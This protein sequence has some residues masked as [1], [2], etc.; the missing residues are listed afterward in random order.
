ME[1]MSGANRRILKRCLL[2]LSFLLGFQAASFA[3]GS[4]EADFKKTDGRDNWEYTYDIS[5]M[6]PGKYNLIVEGKDKAGNVSTA[7]PYNVYIDPKSDLPVAGISNPTPGLRVGGDLHIVGT[8]VDDDGVDRVEVKLDDGEFVKADGREY[9]SYS[10][11]AA[12]MADGRHTVSA[13]GVDINGLVGEPV[14]VSFNLD[15]H[16]PVIAIV[17]H[18]SGT[19]VSGTVTLSGTA[20]DAN[21]IKS[22]ACSQDN[23]KT[24][25]EL[26]L[27]RGKDDTSAQFELTVDT[28][29]LADGPYAYWFGSLD[30]TGSTGY[31]AFLLFVDNTGPS[32]EILKPKSDE[33]VSGRVAVIGKITE[34]IGIKSFSYDGGEANRGAIE[35]APGNPY[36]IHEFDFSK[37]RASSA[38][39]LFTVVD[40]VGNTTTKDLTVQIL[41]DE[42]DLPVV[43]LRS[44][45]A[46]GVYPA[47]VLLSGSVRD[48]DGVK[49]VQYSIDGGKPV[50]LDSR[51]AFSAMLTELPAGKHKL[52]IH[53][54]DTNDRPGKDVTVEFTSRGKPPAVTVESVSSGKESVPFRPGFEIARDKGAVL[55]GRISTLGQLKSLE[56]SLNGAPA[57]KLSTKGADKAGE[58]SF[59][60]RIPPTVS[61][62]MVTLSVRATDQSDQVGEFKSIIHVTNYSKRNI[63][64]GIYFLQ[65]R[66][67][68]DGTILLTPEMPLVGIFTGEEIRSVSIEPPSDVLSIALDGEKIT[69]SPRGTGAAGPLH[70]KVV[71]AKGRVFTS[72]ELGFQADTSGGAASAAID[73]SRIV[74]GKDSFEYSPG[75]RL[76]ID[77][78]TLLTGTAAIAAQVKSAEYALQG[79]PARGF[80]LKKLDT[81]GQY[82][83]EIPLPPELPYGKIDLRMAV[84]DASG[85]K[86]VL[87]T[88]FFRVEKESGTDNDGEGIYLADSRIDSTGALLLAPGESIGGYFNG[89]P[90]KEIRLDPDTPLLSAAADG[91][92][93]RLSAVK[94]GMPASVR[95]RLTTVDGDFFQSDPYTVRSDAG[96]PAVTVDS[97]RTGDWVGAR[98]RLKGSAS[99]PNGI[100]KL[101]YALNSSDAFTA[102]PPAGG[103][104][105]SGFDI[106]LDLA[107]VPDG[108]VGLTVRAADG[109]G[110][111]SVVSLRFMK[112]SEG[113]AISLVTPP[114]EDPVNGLITVTGTATDAGAVDQVEFSDDG[115]TYA[116]VTGTGVFSMPLDLSKYTKLPEAFYFRARDKSGNISVFTAALNVQ[117]ETDIPTVQIQIP[118]DGEVL[119]SDFTISGMVFDDDGVGSISYRIDQGP[120]QKLPGSNSFDIPLRLEDMSDNEHAIEVMAEDLNGVPS[121]SATSTFKISKAEPTSR[122]TS[123]ALSTTTRGVITLAGESMDKNGI[124]EISISFDNGQTFNLAEGKEKWAYRL[125]TQILK[126]GTYSIIIKAVDAYGTEGLFS[127]LL[128]IDNQPPQIILD[129]PKDGAPVTE[130]LAV[131][132]RAIDNIDLTSLKATLAPLGLKGSSPASWDLPRKGHFSSALDLKAVAAGWYNLTLEATDKAEN[133]A[134][135]SR[136]V[137]V[138]EKKAVNTV[139]ILFPVNGESISGSFT[140]AG[141]VQSSEKVTEVG[142]SVDGQAAGTIPMNDNGYFTMAVTPESLQDG[143][144]S[145]EAQARLAGDLVIR[146]EPRSIVYRKLGPWIRITSNA[147]GDFVTSRPF[148]TGEAGFT[149]EPADPA[150]K[151]AVARAQRERDAHRIERIEVSLDNGKSFTAV[152][153]REKWQYRLE[154]QNYPDGEVRFIARAVFTDGST[155]FD[156]TLLTI[157]DTPPQVVLLSPREEGRFNGEISLLGTA[158][159]EN[160]IS[161]VRAAVRQGDK[162]NYEVPGF[163]QGLYFE[164]HALGA[165]EWDFGIGLTFFDDNVKLQAQV[166]TAPEGRFSGLVIGTKL[167]ANI[168]RLPFSYFLG[169]DWDLLSL[170]LAI[171]ANFSYVTNSG[172]AIAFTDKGLII[173]GVVGQLEFPIVKLKSWPLFRTYS[174]Y[175]E[176]QLW[177]ISSDISAGFVSRMA[178]GARIGLF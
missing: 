52:A 148:I 142:F 111:Q 93:I 98:L 22:L 146:S 9:W 113:P 58:A 5:T 40:L 36:W 129:T 128:N 87:S 26:P 25:R 132:G 56:C 127:T 27:R 12:S 90:V 78:S 141:R 107:D 91:N 159:D 102:I 88:S 172:S 151:E 149:S 23:K 64:P 99:D 166:G 32:I 44:P 143:T 147:P 134:K 110:R 34:R 42:A 7:G 69:V 123:P 21:G 4:K 167:L 176:Y 162:A 62:G 97:P 8:C 137:L 47:D 133:S 119:R 105:S 31:T 71:S 138:Q 116:A 89:R 100:V 13:R 41:P 59:E 60:I 108:D 165:T 171:G 153:G 140:L 175:T 77:R 158:H 55:V 103:S 10:L 164:G 154:T 73:F 24:F 161:Q 65:T 28:K 75:M 136:N 81:A 61:F 124:K 120:I 121:K 2:S 54:V 160:G 115:K 152:S 35:L 169:P 145:L 118:Q 20:T 46:N 139:Q 156:E 79:G 3:A 112:D 74:Q 85:Q 50:V 18:K 157:D 66:A 67:Q 106:P 126:D 1:D 11:E 80:G 177:F 170:S 15:T 92:F 94:E 51:E 122:L 72:P 96:A 19:I 104:G 109:A 37:P 155:A 53:G 150:D 49:A 29:K 38:R 131:D 39:I 17:S 84:T 174:L 14:S 70:V 83:F 114:A 86:T 48:D 163:I 178:F 168:F 135:I 76:V 117:Q 130:S 6:A 95:L 144:H 82:G 101:E 68:A 16:R 125:D 63:E 45:A 30:M 173:G 33:K 43:T 57:Q